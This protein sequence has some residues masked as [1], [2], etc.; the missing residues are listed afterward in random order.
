MGPTFEV[1]QDPRRNGGYRLR[2]MGPDGD[3]LADLKDLPTLD[4][5]RR[6]IMEIREVAA[7]ALVVDHT[8]RTA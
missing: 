2:L 5:V 3:V 6:M 7:Q 1:L 4:S 8:A